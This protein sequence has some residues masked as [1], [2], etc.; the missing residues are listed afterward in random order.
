MTSDLYAGS[1]GEFSTSRNFD[2][3]TYPNRLYPLPS[4]VN[5][6]AGTGV[7]NLLC[8]SDLVVYGDGVATTFG[9]H[10]L[11]K[12]TGG[13]WTELTLTRTTPDPDFK[14]FVEYLKNPSSRTLLFSGGG[15][16]ILMA[17]P[18]NV[19]AQSS[20]GLTYTDISQGYVHPADDILYIGYSNATATYIAA[21]NAGSWNDTA[22]TLP[23]RYK[24]V[25]L[26][27]FGNYLAIACTTYSTGAIPAGGPNVSM[28]F[29]WDRD[30]SLTTVSESVSWGDN[31]LF[32]LN[33]LDG[34]LIGISTYQ[35][36]D[37]GGLIIK[38]YTG[39]QPEVLKEVL[40]T[41]QDPATSPTYSVYPRVN[42]IHRGRMY[43]SCDMS[44]GGTSPSYKGLWSVGKNRFGQWA[45][46]VERFASTDGSD[47]S[48]LAAA[49]RLDYLFA[50][51]TASGTLTVGSTSADGWATE[52]QDPA[53]YESV[54]N[55]EM[56]DED[57]GKQKQFASAACHFL[58]LPTTGQ[59]VMKYRLDSI[60]AWTT[61]FTKTATSPDTNLLA[62]EHPIAGATGRN[63][64]F[65]IES[66]GS[67]QVVGFSYKYQ[68][69]STNI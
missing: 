55:P 39:G 38:A 59:V 36:N 57:K 5:D 65:R 44:S 21:N 52:Y 4:M 62:Y 66:T 7:G 35:G 27:K 31:S 29:F 32:A 54:T 50:N 63:I 19:Q 23:K 1:L 43:F 24:V 3:I 9:D 22:L 64:E 40:V 69:L 30:T 6:T 12:S 37:H 28:V 68:P 42:F 61:L 48:V 17:D 45:V 58:T 8:A 49:F 60:G 2:I 11:W 15:T 14:L 16:D 46:T 67:A 10:A 18:A 33:N 20:H 51:H 26:T 13:G 34:V 53:I 41:R 47:V 25:A 56:P